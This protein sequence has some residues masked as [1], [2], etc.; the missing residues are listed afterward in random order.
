MCFP[1]A[2]PGAMQFGITFNREPAETVF[3]ELVPLLSKHY[4]EIA[5]HCGE[6][7]EPD[8]DLYRKLDEGGFLRVFTAR[9]SFRD[10]ELVGYSVFIVRPHQHSRQSLQAFSDLLYILPESRGFGV[11]FLLYIENMLRKDGAK[12]IYN[13][14][15]PYCDYSPMLERMGYDLVDK[16]YARRL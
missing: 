4:N 11:E 13:S 10:N 7:L 6:P 2:L 5:I 8:W 16:V 15:T 12:V 9:D 1:L 14:V 3:S